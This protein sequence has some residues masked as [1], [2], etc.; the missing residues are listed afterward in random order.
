MIRNGVAYKMLCTRSNT[1]TKSN[2]QDLRLEEWDQQSK[3][4]NQ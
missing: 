1:S 2:M 3:I 4:K